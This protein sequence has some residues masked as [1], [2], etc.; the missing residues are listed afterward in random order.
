VIVT[1]IYQRSAIT[2]TLVSQGDLLIH[3]WRHITN[4]KMNHERLRELGQT[5]LRFVENPYVVSG[6]GGLIAG[7]GTG[8]SIA[9]PVG[10]VVGGFLGLA[11]SEAL[12]FSLQ[13]K[14]RK[15]DYEYLRW[16]LSQSS[17]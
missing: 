3:D 16:R 4:Q 2:R 10:L 14:M 1:F 7:G 13:R 5:A 17:K 11:S 9:G 6:T 12:Q 8:A 15:N